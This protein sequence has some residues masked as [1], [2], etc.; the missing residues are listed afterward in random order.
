MTSYEAVLNDATQL[1]VEQ[2]VQIIDALWETVP[3]EAALSL[4]PEW[5]DEI[6]RRSSAYEA[7]E[8]ETFTW[9]QVRT[10]A[11]RRAEMNGF[12]LKSHPLHRTTT[13]MPTSGMSAKVPM[14]RH[15]LKGP[16][17]PPCT[18][19]PKGLIACRALIGNIVNASFTA[20]LIKSSIANK[21][22]ESRL[23]P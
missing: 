16:L 21:M 14:Q 13:W 9:E 17:T 3:E 11:R 5:M 4:S 20:F 19:F 10:E 2:R 22:K 6:E 8:M 12:L 23:W 18:E 7:G 15:G 1:P